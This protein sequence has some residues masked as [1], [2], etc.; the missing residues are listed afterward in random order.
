VISLLAEFVYGGVTGWLLFKVGAELR[1]KHIPELELAANQMQWL[2]YLSIISILLSFVWF[3]Y[4]TTSERARA[5]F[6]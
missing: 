6:Q 4:F 5:V 2:P 3:R 1:E